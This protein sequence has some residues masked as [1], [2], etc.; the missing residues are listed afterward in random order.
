[1]F[2]ENEREKVV[3]KMAEEDVLF[4]GGV[5]SAF[6]T[7]LEAVYNDR[8]AKP[9]LCPGSWEMDGKSAGTSGLQLAENAVVPFTGRSIAS[10]ASDNATGTAHSSPPN[11]VVRIFNCS[12]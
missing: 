7:N 9:E 5:S 8:G 4:G 3:K 6:T 1:M 11:A 12:K 2:C 10:E